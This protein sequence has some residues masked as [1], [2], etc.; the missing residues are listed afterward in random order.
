MNVYFLV[1]GEGT[2]MKLYPKWLHY[3]KP[4]LK[5][6]EDWEKVTQND[7]FIFSGAGIPSIY[8]HTVNAIQNIN[9]NP[10]FDKLIVCLDA[11]E[12]PIEESITEIKNYISKSGV[13]L[14][15]R[16]S[17]EYII[18]NVCIETWFLGN[19]KIVKRNPQN[20]ELREFIEYY[21][22]I[23]KD[24]ELMPRKETFRTKAS[25]HYTYF[26]KIVEERNLSYS[27]AQ[28]NIATEKSFLDE[29]IN[30]TKETNHLPT[31]KFFFDVVSKIS[32]HT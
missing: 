29:L 2:E 28:P 7:Y 9:E 12:M 6:V 22:I 3:L 23:E 4:E 13:I 26:K 11:E 32:T 10:V 15:K 1:E 24:P 31:L 25:F 21:N 27:K 20:R 19:R 30:R 5:E 18:Q 8:K 14:N 17:I 16:C